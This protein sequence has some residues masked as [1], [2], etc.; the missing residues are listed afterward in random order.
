MFRTAFF[1][2]VFASVMVGSVERCLAAEANA[3]G[4]SFTTAPFIPP[5]IV[6][7]LSTW[8]SDGG[9]QAIAVNLADAVGSNRYFGEVKRQASASG[10]NPYVFTDSDCA[11]SAPAACA[12]SGRTSFGYRLAGRAANGV[13][14]LFTEE[15]GGGSGRFRNL[16]FVIVEKD[17]GLNYDEP[18]GILRLSRERWLIKKLGEVPLGDRYVGKI[19]V[20]GNSVHIEADRHDPSTGVVE[21]DKVIRLELSPR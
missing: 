8:L 7:D 13:F 20:T 15:N 12:N 9:D 16:M 17:K 1:A 3:S 10:E 14:V 2:L 5:R 11:D 19:T 4:Y 6:A 18:N 21:Q